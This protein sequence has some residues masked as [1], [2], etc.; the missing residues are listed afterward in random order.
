MS[1]KRNSAETV[2]DMAPDERGTYKAVATIYKPPPLVKRR[3]PKIFEFFDGFVYG[4]GA[5]EGFLIR[6]DEISRNFKR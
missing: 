1:E 2:I 4:L 3:K 5:L 6:L